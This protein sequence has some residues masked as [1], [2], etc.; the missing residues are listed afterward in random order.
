METCILRFLRWKGCRCGCLSPASCYLSAIAL[1]FVTAGSL[2][3]RHSFSAS[4]DSL[5]CVQLVAFT[6]TVWDNLML[7]DPQCSLMS[8]ESV[9]SLHSPL[10][11][12][13]KRDPELGNEYHC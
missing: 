3:K 1:P 9:K 10:E 2:S 11:R 13:V 8:L 7:F 6:G 12:A 5:F 4:R